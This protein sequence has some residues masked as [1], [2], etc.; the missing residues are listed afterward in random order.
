MV[1]LGDWIFRVV[2]GFVGLETPKFVYIATKSGTVRNL[3]S[4]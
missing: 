2:I 1:S 4:R 3:N